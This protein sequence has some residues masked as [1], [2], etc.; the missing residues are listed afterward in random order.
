MISEIAAGSVIASPNRRS[1]V[2]LAST[3]VISIVVSREIDRAG[4]GHVGAGPD[5]RSTSRSNDPAGSETRTCVIGLNVPTGWAIATESAVP[6]RARCSDCPTGEPNGVIHDVVDVAVDGRC[7][8]CAR[9]AGEV[10]GRRDRFA[11]QLGERRVVHALVGAEHDTRVER[12]TVRHR[13]L[14]R[15]VPVPD[16]T[17]SGRSGRCGAG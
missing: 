17:S 6:S 10:S 15:A 7:A 12:G 13:E 9:Y 5:S 2:V 3:A 1:T 8:A 11:E 16:R 14:P 4:E